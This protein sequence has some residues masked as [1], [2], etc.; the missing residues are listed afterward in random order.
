M[1]ILLVQTSFL[2]DTVLSTPVIGALDLLFPS[3]EIWCL[4]TPGGKELLRNDPRLSGIL[5]YD[6]RGIDRGWNGMR[7]MAQQLAALKF[8][9]VYSLHRSARTALMLFLSRLPMRIG[10]REAKLSFLYHRRVGRAREA[11]DVLR[12]LSLLK[13]ELPPEAQFSTAL[14][15]HLP[16]IEQTSA[17]LRDLLT[18]PAYVLLVPASVWRT[19]MWHWERYRELAQSLIAAGEKVVLA[20]SPAE[21]GVCAK[22]AKGLALTDLSGHSSI[23]DLMALVGHSRLLIC[24]DSLA[25]HLGSAFKV[26]CIAV[27]CSTVPEF[28]FGPWENRA[29]VLGVTGLECRPCGRHGHK[30]CPTGTERCMREIS[31]QQVYQSVLR[32][33][34]AH[35]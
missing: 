8:D 26:P 3:A 28:G 25:L 22:I 21:V 13:P 7:R 1:K 23:S 17:R 4:T 34:Q 31:S 35:E 29:E 5:V 33:L 12:N 27:F 32:V 14:R 16:S 20:G 18:G 11:H 2:G 9:R 24:N 30:T 10:F 6:K 15:L 19:K